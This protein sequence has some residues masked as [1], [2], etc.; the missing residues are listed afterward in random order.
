M[1]TGGGIKRK[2]TV[3]TSTST[4]KPRL[5][6]S[7]E[8][9]T[10]GVSPNFD[11]IECHVCKKSFSKKYFTN[12]LQS[13]AHKN[14]V[15][16]SYKSFTN[17]QLIDTAFGNRLKTFRIT[18][19][20]NE[21]I[22]EFE[23]PEVF[24]EGIKE[25]IT[26][27][28]NDCVKEQKAVKVNFLLHAD[29]IQQSKNLHNSFDFQTQN[30]IF[31]TGTI[32][33]NDFAPVISEI[34]SK[35]SNFER[36]DSGWSLIKIKHIDVNINKFNPLRGSSY[37]DLPLDIKHKK[38]VINVKNNDVQCFKWAILSALFPV[39]RDNER[40]SAYIGKQNELKFD[41]I[42]FPIKLKDINKF[43]ALNN[44]SIN[45]FGLEY[46]VESRS[47]K[48]VGPLYF[49][50][51]RKSRHVNLLYITNG[52]NGHY[53][54][55]KNL[56]RLVNK[57]LTGMRDAVH[58]CDGC[59]LY[60][61]TT[62]RLNEHQ[63]FDC[64]HVR[65]E[66]PHENSTLS[67]NN[68][69]RKL[70]IPF[71]V[72]ADFEA[73]LKPIQ[74]CVND[75]SKS[76]T[77]NV[78]QHEVYSFGYYVKCS[79]DD[80]L[81]RYKTYS[82]SDCAKV[83]MGCLQNELKQIFKKNNF[84]VQPLPLTNENQLQIETATNCFICE[85]ILNSEKHIYHDWQTGVYRG[86]AHEACSA[87]FRPPRF[88][89]VVLHN[90]SNYDA[91]FI[92]QAL[93]FVEGDIEVIPQNKEKYIS[94][95]KV[96]T[97]NNQQV[98][99]R[100][101]DSLKF[102][103]CSLQSLANNLQDE[104]FKELKKSFSDE[105]DFNLLKRKGIYPYE[106]MTSFESLKAT[107]LP[108]KDKFYSSLTDSIVSHEDY[109]HAENVW[110]H[111]N[112][113]NMEDY[114]NLYLKTDV[115][116][117]TDIF[118]NFREVCLKT[119]DLDSLYYY[120]AP[121]L[122]WESMLKYT[123]V[124][125]EL[126]SDFDKVAFVKSGIR[127]GVSQCSHRHAE[128]NNKFMSNFDDN[129][130][131]SYLTYLD[132]N[133]LYGWAMSQYLPIGDFQ[134]VD[135]NTDFNVSNTSDFGYILEVDLDYPDNL[136]DLHSD[137]PLCP[138]NIKVGGCKQLKLVPNLY[139]KE[140]YVIH[141]RNLKQ[142]I[143]MGLKLT[144]IHRILK[145]RQ[146]PWLQKYIDLNTQLRASATSDFEKDFF[147]LM[148]NSIFGKTMENIEKRVDVKLRTHWENHGKRKGVEHLIAKPEFHSLSIFTENLVAIQLR[149][150]KL[151][152]N[153]PIFLGFCILDISKTLMYD[154]H[155]NYMKKKYNSNCRMLYTDTDSLVYQLFT[156]NFYEDIKPDIE[157]FFD[158]SDYPPDNI[159]GFPL[160]NK[161]KI[162]LFK[163]ENNG[164]IFN[165]FV[166]L[167]SKMYAMDIQDKFIAKSKGVN[168][169][170]TKKFQMENYKNVLFSK[171]NK[172]C[173]MFRFRSLK[174]VIYTQKSNKISLSYT[175]T[176]RYIKPNSTETLA[177]GHYSIRHL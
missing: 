79:Y 29:F 92:V 98:H 91:H 131:S 159:F 154:F 163:D 37:I 39:T 100:F 55:I 18:S 149:K 127:G 15:L 58:I 5:H 7:Q 14:N 117:L 68:Y 61:T 166:G 112:C 38:A 70:K 99:L 48:V 27:L 33:E 78:Q 126:L 121:G 67:F 104:Q 169:C 129:K 73:F 87:K 2:A 143:E 175:D 120:T 158:T 142:C 65:T 95:S 167:R 88:V 128:A 109:K 19:N 123:Q 42:P 57:Q 23:T 97:I 125:L 51:Q 60:F 9:S 102:L 106:C 107:S 53:C 28:I 66:L 77:T 151:Y 122:S 171:E 165:E 84:Q 13:N 10:S 150:T 146:S 132:A 31:C 35:I 26:S 74:H 80:R 152:Y 56:S 118:E 81:S 1:Q 145:F 164:K 76:H 137:F 168:K 22:L 176:K 148:N 32:L 16:S 111:F 173:E 110:R 46:D 138:E 4:K 69:E 83:F 108:P 130:P 17:V 54:Y 75:P 93:N 8:P 72:Y 25:T 96:L 133:N 47:N 156:E 82:G 174:H 34:C 101:I 52:T 124:K 63:K 140:K 113:Q 139:N 172:V 115:L 155:Y 136:H 41:G 94:F 170:V 103:N 20:V 62:E 105:V 40:V 114:S 90:L 86:V 43:E 45:V 116:L 153:K 89:P 64:S 50:K 162:G 161:K 30:H 44:I 12:H 49:T 3:G 135:T 160:L 24:L 177:W 59:L 21:T 157:R 6:T 134:W 119:Y 36:K 11:N 144:K 141:Y 147:K 85:N 71:V